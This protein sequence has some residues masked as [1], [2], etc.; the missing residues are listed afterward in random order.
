M[1]AFPLLHSRQ[2]CWEN[3][4]KTPWVG[5]IQKQL[6]VLYVKYYYHLLSFWA[7]KKLSVEICWLTMDVG[8]KETAALIPVEK[9]GCWWEQILGLFQFPRAV[10]YRCPREPCRLWGKE[11][12]YES[13]CF[14][15]SKEVDMSVTVL[16]GSKTVKILEVKETISNLWGL[17]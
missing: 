4:S 5:M 15:G 8:G 2:V 3:S 13:L 6:R 11:M 9:E 7:V 17:F 14:S 1:T 16:S 10:D 12:T